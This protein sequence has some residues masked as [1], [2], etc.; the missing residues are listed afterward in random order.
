[1]LALRKWVNELMIYSLDDSSK[2]EAEETKKSSNLNW[3]IE[4]QSARG[5][6]D[7]APALSNVVNVTRVSFCTHGFPG[8][9]YFDKGCIN[10]TS[11][12]SIVIPPNLFKGEGQLLFMGCETA[13]APF[14]EE[15]LIAAGSHFFKGR[16]GIVGG[17]TVSLVGW[18]SG[19]VLPFVTFH[20]DA[21]PESGKLVLFRLDANGEVIGKKYAR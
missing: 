19:T 13:Q 21:L 1:M 9:V 12:K 15:F 8:G 11:V 16:G 17:A 20:W 18:S 10:A 3:S 7:I 2:G 5:I 14:G 6:K 4:I